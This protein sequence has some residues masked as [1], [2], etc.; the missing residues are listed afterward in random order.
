MELVARGVRITVR[1]EAPWVASQV[2]DLLAGLS[3]PA[4]ARGPASKAQP[5]EDL[6][7]PLMGRPYGDLAGVV[8]FHLQ[9]RDGRARWRSGEIAREL[10]RRG[11]PCPANVTDALNHR[12]QMGYF[13][14]EDRLWSLTESGMRWVEAM[15]E[16]SPERARRPESPPGYPADP[17]GRL[18][19]GG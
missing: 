6:V 10:K 18:P 17:A 12:K 7:A 14:V 1:G 15:L 19:A 4:A 2:R 16:G 8:A 5:L 3:D 9:M 13:Q 11:L